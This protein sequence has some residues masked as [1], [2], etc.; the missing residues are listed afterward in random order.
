MI[1]DDKTIRNILGKEDKMA[2]NTVSAILR[3]IN[4]MQVPTSTQER[5]IQL[6]RKI[7]KSSFYTHL[8]NFLR[9]ESK[10]IQSDDDKY[11]RQQKM[12]RSVLVGDLR[13]SIVTDK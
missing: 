5:A 2:E 9:H 11:L 3:F 8:C 1:G 10:D 6:W 13:Q 12:L 4:Q 7:L